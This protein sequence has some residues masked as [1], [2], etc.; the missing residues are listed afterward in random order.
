MKQSFT[1]E[2]PGWQLIHTPT[3]CYDDPIYV[4]LSNRLKMSL[5]LLGTEVILTGVEKEAIYDAEQ[6][7]QYLLTISGEPV[8]TSIHYTYEG[9]DGSGVYYE[10]DIPATET[11]K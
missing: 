5:G 2:L 7:G 11:I 10:F 1:W 6:G 9:L 3:W 4:R 8:L